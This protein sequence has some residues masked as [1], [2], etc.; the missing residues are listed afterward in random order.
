MPHEFP[1]VWHPWEAWEEVSHNMW[2]T[3]QDR[4]AA[5]CLAIEF[6][7]DHA[8]YG[9]YMR[10]VVREWPISCENALTD[11]YLNHKAWVGHAACAL[12]LRLPEDVV[13]QAWGHLSDEQKLLA[14][15]EAVRAVSEW[16]WAY[17][18]DRRIRENVDEPLLL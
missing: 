1:Q 13:R 2:G 11:P 12:A 14:N 5:V 4:T 8:R 7:G 17:V 3:V 18:E 9:Y 10:R 6:T 15:K 16:R